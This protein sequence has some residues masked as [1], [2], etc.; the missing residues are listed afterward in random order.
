MDTFC[1]YYNQGI[2]KSCSLIAVEYDQQLQHKEKLL[3]SSLK[4]LHAFSLL[5]SVSS[6]VRSFRN[7]A[8]FVVTGT[9][10]EPLI[11][12]A[13][14][15]YL[16]EGRELLEC[17]LHLVEIN[18]LLPAIKDFIR[19][20]RLKPYHAGKK[21][22]ELKGIII[23]HSEETNES[24]VRFILR[25]K[26]ALDRIRKLAPSLQLKCTGIKVVSAN[27]QPVAHAIL[28][29]P[30]E[31]IV[32]SAVSLNH[33]TGG[34]NL[35]LGPQAFVQTNQGVAQQLY[36]SAALWVKELKVKKFM[37][38][39]C[40]QGAFSF[41][42]AGYVEKA[43][44]IEINPEAVAAANETALKLGMDHISFKASDAAKVSTEV[45][46]FSPDAILVNPPRRGLGDALPLMQ[47]AAPEHIIY[48]SCNHLSLASDVTAL[49]GI[50]SIKKVQIFDMF[51]HTAHFETL[52][53]L[54]KN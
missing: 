25:S 23:F 46:N 19:E 35:S 26:E 10:E 54:T 17:P 15:N 34:L 22:G 28:E 1:R 42:A 33:K 9:L 32:T 52:M 51:P 11:G 48:S 7:K 2:C 43:L 21:T 50:Y 45:L 31:I 16:D 6:E 20:A 53:L 41:F 44:G 5:P 27:I 38:L 47:K 4:D 49:S 24:Y 37:E 13:G 36:Q 14:E 12:L 3:L 30:E 8:K 39:F 18:S 29:G 40:G